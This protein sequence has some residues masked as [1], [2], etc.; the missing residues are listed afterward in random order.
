MSRFHEYPVFVPVGDHQTAAIVT[1]PEGNPRGVVVFTTGGGGALR[2]QRFRLWTKAARGLAERGV[3]SVRMEYPGVGDSTGTHRVGL[4]WAKLPVE[5]LVAVSEFAM[6]VTGTEDLGLCGNCAGARSSIRAVA[7]LPTCRSLALFWL[8]PLA[9]T[10]RATHHRLRSA[11]RLMRHAP[12]PVKRALAKAYW[13]RQSRTGLGAG[14]GE[15]LRKAA[16][17]RDLLLIETQSALAGEIPK[18]M[19]ELQRSSNGHRIELRR[20]ESTSMQAF[21]SV[22]EQEIT[23][24]AVIE[25]FEGSLANADNGSNA[26]SSAPEMRLSRSN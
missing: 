2:S 7:S 4:G 19:Q 11:V 8:K 22:S 21:E 16:E 12:A 18:V 5:D 1:V 13:K 17:G 15:T 10:D 14:V 9:S 6:S 20:F 26:G 23:V 25:W 24:D 3:A